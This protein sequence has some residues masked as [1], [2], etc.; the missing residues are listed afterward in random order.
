MLSVADQ[1]IFPLQ[2]F[3]NLGSE[4]RTNTPGTVVNNW[5]WRYSHE[6]LEQADRSRIRHL[7]ELSKRV[8]VADNTDT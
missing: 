3:M 4:H 5:L 1:A 8:P 7:A 2:D 6:M